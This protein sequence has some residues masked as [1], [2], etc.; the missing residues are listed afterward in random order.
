[1]VRFI[2]LEAEEKA[3]E[4]KISAE[5]VQDDLISSMNEAAG[6]QLLRVC[7]D[8]YVCKKILQ[9]LIVQRELAPTE[10]DSCAVALLGK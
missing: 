10:R 1:M 6:K 2:L 4:I 9:E 3:R 7:D 5:D 8:Y